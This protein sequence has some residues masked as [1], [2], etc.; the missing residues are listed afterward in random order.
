[1]SLINESSQ[2]L[3]TRTIIITRD[4]RDIFQYEKENLG[5][6]SYDVNIFVIGF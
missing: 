5:A 4:P 6:P 3:K 2:Y 1:M